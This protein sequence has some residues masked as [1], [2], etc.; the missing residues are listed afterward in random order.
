M[1]DGSRSDPTSP[2]QRILSDSNAPRRLRRLCIQRSVFREESPFK[3][4]FRRTRIRNDKPVVKEKS[5]IRSGS[6]NNNN[7]FRKVYEENL[8]AAM[9][10]KRSDLIERQVAEAVRSGAM[11]VSDPIVRQA[12]ELICNTPS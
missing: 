2:V 11:R 6:N 8:L 12:L 10:T 1:S 4:K 9:S 5:E 7:R 3:K